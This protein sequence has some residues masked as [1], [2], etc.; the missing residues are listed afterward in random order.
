MIN[1]QYNNPSK[2]IF[3]QDSEKEIENLLKEYRVSSLLL[4][5]SGD[6]IKELGIWDT[7]TQ[8]CKKLNITFNESADVV[9]NPKIELV[10]ELVDIGKQHNVDFILA[11]GGGSAIDTAKAVS[12]GIPYE[13]DPWDF[14]DGNSIP[15]TSIPV[16]VITT[17]PSSGSETSNAAIIS[18]GLSKLG[19]EDDMII[20]KFAIMN[21]KF[22]LTLPKYQT[23]CGCADILS[24]LLERYFTETLHVD[25]T[26]YMIE[27]AIK[28]VMLN[29]QRLMTNPTNIDARSEIQW[30][31]SI[32][33]NGILDT[34]RV[35]D[36]GSH[37]IEHE[38]SAQY[39]ITHGEGMAVVFVA[40]CKYMANEKPEKLAQLAN[41]LYGIDYHNYTVHEMAL[42]LADKLKDFFRSLGL[43]TTLGEME[44]ADEHFELMANRATS[45]D[46][47]TVGHYIPL[48]NKRI[49]EIL[50]LAL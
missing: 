6:F 8:A 25:T 19:F 32:A 41:R 1:F 42:T 45:N 24:H 15:E 26:D 3:G 40:W 37:R 48:D 12:L 44:I 33:H 29:S 22:T 4:V 43:K 27:G 10:R 14:F 18:N 35:S 49:V 16:G 17:L 38:I 50:K 34:G 7:V 23:S 9:P 31:A 21:P 2:I 46:T 36:W 5:Y 28:A 47:Q 39:G 13:R 30:L 11:V 20:P